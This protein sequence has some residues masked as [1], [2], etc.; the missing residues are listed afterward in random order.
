MSTFLCKNGVRKEYFLTPTFIIEPKF[1]K[2]PTFDKEPKKGPLQK[3]AAVLLLMTENCASCTKLFGRANHGQHGT[4][5]NSR[6]NNTGYV[7]AHGMHE[8]EV[9]RIGF[10]A[11][12]L[13]DTSCHRNGGNTGTAD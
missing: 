2:E 12:N 13:G 4:S 1:D 7:R 6:T 11:D 3:P 5:R 8:Q 10:L 9:G